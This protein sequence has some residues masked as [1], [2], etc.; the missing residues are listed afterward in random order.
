MML[1]FLALMIVY[2]IWYQ[3]KG[4]ELKKIVQTQ[5]S[6]S[7]IQ[8]VSESGDV[9]SSN[10][11]VTITAVTGGITT[12]GSTNKTGTTTNKTGIIVSVPKITTGTMKNNT[13][14]TLLSGTSIYYGP[15]AIIEK[16]GIKYQYALADEK[17][18]WY[19]YLGTPSYDFVSIARALK[20]SLYTLTTEQ[21]LIQNQLFGNKV[22]FINL[23]EYKD[24][25]VL[26][27]IYLN[28]GIW[29]VQM[30]Y[31]LYHKSKAYLKSL[32]IN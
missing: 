8:I 21:D 11:S 19:I 14:I 24:K 28:D 23:P 10:N 4:N 1:L 18:I 13:G 3:V 31:S 15:I 26:M 25:Q 22:V 32:F 29:L 5:N 16:L 17:G 27:L 20:G 12:T 2:I 30:E 7:T 6:G 9:L